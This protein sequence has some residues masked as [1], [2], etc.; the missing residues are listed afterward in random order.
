MNNRRLIDFTYVYKD[1]I[2]IKG[3]YIINS[4]LIEKKELFFEHGYLKNGHHEFNIENIELADFRENWC[5]QKVRIQGKYSKGQKSGVW[6]YYNKE[7]MKI[8]EVGHMKDAHGKYF[9]YYS[10]NYEK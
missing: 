6:L 3:K 2:N 7:G 5:N 10:I 8:K 4:P 9:E 1:K